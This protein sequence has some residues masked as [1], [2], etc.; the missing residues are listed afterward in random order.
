LFCFIIYHIEHYPEVKQRLKQEFDRVLGNDLTRPIAYKDLDELEYCDAV[1]KEVYRYS[2][3]ASMLGRI[4]VKDDNVGGYNWPEG[5]SFQIHI[6]GIMRHKDYWT[7]PDKFDPD[8]FYRIE[9]SDKYLLEKKKMKNMF[10]LF[11][12]GI[13]NCPGRKLAII[14]LKSLLALIYRKYDVQL[15]DMDAPLKY[16]PD[17][18]NLCK[19]LMIKIKPRKF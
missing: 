17:F 10:S 6:S 15:A 3:M 12:G 11:G 5:T 7:E 2:P 8:R 16:K 1:I 4:N 19:E 9:E 13:R 18:L 14:E